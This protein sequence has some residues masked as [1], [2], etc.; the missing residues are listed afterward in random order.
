MASVEDSSTNGAD[1]RAIG[2]LADLEIALQRFTLRGAEALA[3]IRTQC[4]RNRRSLALRAEDASHEVK[5]CAAALDGADDDDID[6]CR[7]ALE[8]AVSA[9]DDI[10]AWERRVE[11]EYQTF[12]GK[13]ARF[14]A[15]LDRTVPEGRGVLRNKIALLKE[16]RAI[17]LEPGDAAGPAPG[18]TTS[19]GD[20]ATVG[21]SQLQDL[22]NF[23]LP[24]G[25]VW[26][27]LSEI[28]LQEELENVQAAGD[29]KKVDK[30]TMRLGMISLRSNVLPCLGADTDQRGR[31][32]FADIDRASSQ[33]Y[34]N[35]LQRI[36]DAFFGESHIH[37]ER[38]GTMDLLSITNGRH[39]V[40][41][42]QE[43]GWDAVPAKAEESSS[44]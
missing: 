10:R 33:S 38:G 44:P 42:A 24:S 41:L 34:E 20:A 3:A 12:R 26:V 40:R 25:F 13:A 23:R 36:Y 29:Y 4:D 28:N 16:Y 5:R 39:R 11:A 6:D 2:A 43:L 21:P 19:S 18:M 17:Q 8:D 22:R 9:R 27:P 30:E 37:L 14:D 32:Y 15:M 7:R 35:G 1:V 31:D